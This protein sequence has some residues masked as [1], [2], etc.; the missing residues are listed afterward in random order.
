MDNPEKLTTFGIGN[1]LAISISK[2]IC[3]ERK[4]SYQ[5]VSL[6]LPRDLEK[7]WEDIFL[8]CFFSLFTFS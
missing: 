3:S 4:P 8:E 2:M 6:I 1:I 5:I 7:Q